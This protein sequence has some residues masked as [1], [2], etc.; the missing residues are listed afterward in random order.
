MEC[1]L[2]SPGAWPDF[3][4]RGGSARNADNGGRGAVSE[5]SRNPLPVGSQF[6]TRGVF[7]DSGGDGSGYQELFQL[8]G[9][10]CSLESVQTDAR[11]G[12]REIRRRMSRTVTKVTA[13]TA[14]LAGLVNNEDPP[15]LASIPDGINSLR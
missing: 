13:D 4:Q 7:P 1:G 10:T 14:S 5:R 12:V 3:S 6:R 8:T 2:Y 11:S 9:S 15:S